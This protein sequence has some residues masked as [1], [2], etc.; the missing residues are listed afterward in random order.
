M[1]GAIRSLHQEMH[2][3]FG[4][5]DA[6]VDALDACVVIAQN[7]YIKQMMRAMEETERTVHSRVVRRR[8]DS[9]SVVTQ[10]REI[11]RSCCAPGVSDLRRGGGVESGVV[12]RVAGVGAS[13]QVSRA[14]G[15]GVQGCE[16]SRGIE[17]RVY[18][19]DRTLQNIWDEFEG[20]LNGGPSLND[21]NRKMG[22]SWRDRCDHKNYNKLLN[23]YKFMRR[24]HQVS[25]GSIGTCTSS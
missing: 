5:M 11:A 14:V 1:T 16:S 7:H 13:S 10:P 21:L 4:A 19:C 15:L 6:R 23:V 12:G 20:G 22:S 18:I 17:Y 25:G 3:C 8:V 9:H 24:Y 2:Q